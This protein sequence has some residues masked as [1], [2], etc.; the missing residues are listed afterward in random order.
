MVDVPQHD[1]V[2]IEIDANMIEDTSMHLSCIVSISFGACGKIILHTKL[3]W[4][5]GVWFFNLQILPC[6]SVS[7]IFLPCFQNSEHS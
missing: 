4:G 1:T 6:V 5:F 2:M 3:R 7:G